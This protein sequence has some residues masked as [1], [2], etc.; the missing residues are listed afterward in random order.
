MDQHSD[1]YQKR[2]MKLILG[3]IILTAVLILWSL[4]QDAFQS[5]P[6]S[7]LDVPNTNRTPMD[8][9]G[10]HTGWK[11]FDARGGGPV[12]FLIPKPISLFPI[13]VLGKIR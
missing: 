10:I 7:D 4:I 5:P 8:S 11:P 12:H 9:P 1:A 3:A 2:T 13:S 6:D